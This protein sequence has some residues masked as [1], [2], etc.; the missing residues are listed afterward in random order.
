MR[1]AGISK[2]T[3]YSRFADKES[4]FRAIMNRQIVHFSGA[5]ILGSDSA[6]SQ[7]EKG[8]RDY[9][10]HMLKASL[11]GDLLGV[12]RL[13]YS[14]SHRFPEL[15]RAAAERTERGIEQIAAFID[16]CARK[17]GVSC[18]DSRGVAEVFILSIRGWY[19]NVMLTNQKIS[20]TRREQW[21][22]RAVHTLLTSREDW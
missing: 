4:L 12:N 15:G 14:E 6:S 18:R 9:A 16:E 22:A 2:T 8:L 17:D 1:E 10:D 11:G 7:L 13:I 5:R 21:V 19:I 20:K 3:L